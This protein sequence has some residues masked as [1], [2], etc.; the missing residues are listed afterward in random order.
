MVEAVSKDD[1]EAWTREAQ[2]EFARAGAVDVA[3]R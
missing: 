1:F 2:E 3:T